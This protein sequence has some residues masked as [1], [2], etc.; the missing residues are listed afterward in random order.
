[1]ALLYEYTQSSGN[2]IDMVFARENLSMTLL[3]IQEFNNQFIQEISKLEI[4][5]DHQ[6]CS[7]L[8]SQFLE[9]LLSCAFDSCTNSDVYGGPYIQIEEFSLTD[10]LFNLI[11]SDDYMHSKSASRV[12]AILEDFAMLCSDDLKFFVKNKSINDEFEEE[13]GNAFD[14]EFEDEFDYL[15]DEDVAGVIKS[16][17]DCDMFTFNLYYTENISLVGAELVSLKKLLLEIKEELYE[18]KY[19]K[20]N[21]A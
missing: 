14:D 6:I 21:A 17:F 9:V 3:G 16:C 13:L 2:N 11:S 19:I 8:P 15:D 10:E 5:S 20:N 1:M 7:V 12:N 4:Y 18:N